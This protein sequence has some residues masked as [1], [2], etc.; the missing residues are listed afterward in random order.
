M[1]TTKYTFKST[2]HQGGVRS[3]K[4]IIRTAYIQIIMPRQM[5]SRIDL[6]VAHSKINNSIF[7]NG[8]KYILYETRTASHLTLKQSEHM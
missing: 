4:T 2:A 5:T 7:I 6:T 3:H 1:L 8:I